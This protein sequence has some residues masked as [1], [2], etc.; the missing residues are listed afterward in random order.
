VVVRAPVRAGARLVVRAAVVPFAVVRFAVVRFA[1]VR[2][3]VAVFRVVDRP[4][5]VR[6][7]LAFLAGARFAVRFAV[8]FFAVDFRAPVAFLAGARF[9]VDLRAGA[10]L[11]VVF[12]AVV[13][14]F[15]VLFR[16]VVFRAVVF[17]AVVER[18]VLFAAVR[19]AGARFAVVVFFAVVP[20]AAD[21]RPLAVFLADARAVDVRLPTAVLVTPVRTA[22]PAADT[23]FAARPVVAFFAA[24][25]VLLLTGTSTRDTGSSAHGRPR[26]YS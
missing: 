13:D 3:A 21:V 26:S 18:V 1:V 22:V 4:V 17:R 23:R 20:P 8:V 7:A 9:A 10:R 2:F 6:A 14:F 5:D 11:A 24:A 19:L 25:I 12:R 16:A 15:A